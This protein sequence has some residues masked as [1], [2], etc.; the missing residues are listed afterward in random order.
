MLKNVNRNVDS[1]T[2]CILIVNSPAYDS[3][4][5]ENKSQKVVVFWLFHS[6]FEIKLFPQNLVSNKFP[7][8]SFFKNIFQIQQNPNSPRHVD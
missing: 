5:K 2:Y 4:K 3:I 7:N 1:K 8:F 6:G